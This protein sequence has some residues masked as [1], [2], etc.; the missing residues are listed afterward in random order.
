MGYLGIDISVDT[1]NEI[2]GKV[3]KNNILLFVFN[4]VFILLLS[5]PSYYCKDGIKKRWQKKS[6]IQKIHTKLNLKC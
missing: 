6:G 3:L 2:K 5:D 1:L 4:R